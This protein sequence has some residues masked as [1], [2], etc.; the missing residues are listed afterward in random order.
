MY[1]I[2]T[3]LGREPQICHT[4][5]SQP[6]WS[7]RMQPA[8]QKGMDQ[9]IIQ[10]VKWVLLG[11]CQGSSN[12]TQMHLFQALGSHFLTHCL[13]QVQIFYARDKD[14]GHIWS[15]PMGPLVR[16]TA[17]NFFK[18]QFPCSL[19]L[20]PLSQPTYVAPHHPILQQGPR[21]LRDGTY[22]AHNGTKAWRKEASLEVAG[23]YRVP[24]SLVVL[25]Q[26]LQYAFTWHE[27]ADELFNTRSVR[28]GS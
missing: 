22:T 3:V 21:K 27:G 10:R 11:C 14:L 7:L 1:N 15:A 16:K 19:F 12:L 25:L 5:S 20:P 17:P 4:G 9:P 6:I 28:E 8:Q 23:T 24:A 26:I 2:L 18:P 13:D